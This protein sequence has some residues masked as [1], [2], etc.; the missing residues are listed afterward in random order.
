MSFFRES[1]RRNRLLTVVGHIHIALFV[2]TILLL[3]VDERQVMGVN[4]WIKPMK[5][6]FSLAI[7]LWTLAWLSAYIHK[8]RWRIKTVSIIIAVVI[9]IESTCLLVQAARGTTSHYNIA[10]DFDSTIYSTMG[11]M[12]GIDMLMTA[13][14]LY[15]FARPSVK[16][17]AVYLWSI[18]VG[19]SIFL[20]GGAIGGIMIANNG[21]TVGAPDGGAGLPFLNWSTVAGDLRIAHGLALHGLQ[22]MPI[23]GYLISRSARVPTRLYGFVLLALA[24]SIYGLA[25]FT[26]YQQAIFGRPFI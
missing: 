10:T 20:I 11:V 25:V 4:T 22:V 7:Y 26:S 16:L 8:P 24:T 9:L 3:V 18:R 5:F 17:H 12:I 1:F 15:F 21:H 23:I 2:L 19:L 13:L 6:M 14:V